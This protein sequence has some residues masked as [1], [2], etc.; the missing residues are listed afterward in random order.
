MFFK[1]TMGTFGLAENCTLSVAIEIVETQI[2]VWATLELYFENLVFGIIAK[3]NTDITYW[4][5][6]LTALLANQNGPCTV[7]TIATEICFHVKSVEWPLTT[8]FLQDC[9]IFMIN[10]S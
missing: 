8:T 2:H 9:F 10:N 5:L 3:L 4:S 6:L 7:L 1:T